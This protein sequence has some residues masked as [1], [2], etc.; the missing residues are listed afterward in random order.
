MTVAVSG[1]S[2]VNSTD[3]LTVSGTSERRTWT[4]PCCACRG[5]PALFNSHVWPFD[6][7]VFQPCQECWAC[8]LVIALDR[9]VR[10]PNRSTHR[11]HI[12]RTT[13][14]DDWS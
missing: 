8:S 2:V 10:V 11:R 9:R 13:L 5:N 1:Q 3:L 7:S 12:R 14:Q 6:W 4:K